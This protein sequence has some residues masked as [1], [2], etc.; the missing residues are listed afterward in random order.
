MVL[1]HELFQD[2]FEIAYSDFNNQTAETADSVALICPA[3]TPTSWVLRML[4]SLSK[5]LT[6]ASGGNPAFKLYDIDPDTYE[7]MDAKV[8][9]GT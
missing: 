5:T 4:Q 9:M 8:F 3:L 7:V 2:Q 1:A 6:I